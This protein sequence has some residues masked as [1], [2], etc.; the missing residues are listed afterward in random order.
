MIV[1]SSMS[2]RNHLRNLTEAV[3]II[4]IDSFSLKK[5]KR[6]IITALLFVIDRLKKFAKILCATM[7]VEQLVMS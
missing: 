5:C 2:L 6:P 4:T 7:N 1:V 3:V